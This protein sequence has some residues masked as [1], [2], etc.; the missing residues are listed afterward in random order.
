MFPAGQ[1]EEK[2]Y[3][4]CSG[5]MIEAP[6][7]WYKGLKESEFV[8]SYE[9]LLQGGYM[10]PSSEQ[11]EFNLANPNL[12][13]YNAFYMIPKDTTIVN[14]EIRKRRENLYNTST[15]RLYMAYVKYREFGE[16]E[17]AAAAYQEWR[18]AVEKIKQD[19]PYSL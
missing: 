13:L 6:E 14:E 18:E 10:H 17:K 15:D 4:L 9:G 12:G 5:G 1:M 11:I 16:E 3:L 7:D 8:D 19:N 2:I